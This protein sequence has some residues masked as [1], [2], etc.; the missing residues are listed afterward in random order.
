MKGRVVV[1]ALALVSE[2]RP[3]VR[4]DY[5]RLY[6]INACHLLRNPC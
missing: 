4:I 1:V 6:N 2:D 3:G 5:R